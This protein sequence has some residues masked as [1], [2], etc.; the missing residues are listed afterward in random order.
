MCEMKLYIPEQAMGQR[1]NQKGN[2]KN[3]SRQMRM[4][5]Q[6]TKMHGMQQ[7]QL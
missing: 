3:T 1:V 6:P 2:A 4:E 5:T 7:K